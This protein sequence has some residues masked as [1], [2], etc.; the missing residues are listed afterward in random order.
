MS[1]KSRL[2]F[3]IFVF[4]FFIMHV[5]AQQK[6]TLE[7]LVPPA[8]NAAELGKY[9]TIPVGTLTGT[10][11]ISF[12]L[13]EI[14]TG[15]LK[16]PI[17]LSYHA[18]GNQVNQ[19]STDVG[20]GWCVMAGG[21][22]SRTVYGSPDNSTNGYFNVTPPSYSTLLG[23]TNYFTMQLYAT[24]P[25]YDLEPDLFVYNM[26]GRSGKFIYT[27]NQNFMTIPFDPI[28]IQKIPVSGSNI[29][30]QITDDNGTIYQFNQFSKTISDIYPSR[31]TISTWYLTSMISADMADTIRFEYETIHQDDPIEQHIY[32]IGMA[33]KADGTTYTSYFVRGD[34]NGLEQHVVNTNSYDELLVK[35]ITFKNGYIQ[36]NRNTVR[37]DISSQGNS[38]D[39]MLVYNNVNP[40]KKITF[41]HDYYTAVPFMDFWTCYRLKL[42]GFVESD[43][44][45]VIKKEHK[46]DY[47]TN[48]FPPYG[49]YNIDY[50]GFSNGATNN[51]LIPTTT[52]YGTDINIVSFCNGDSFCNNIGSNQSW[53][54]GNANREP[55]ATYMKTGILNKITYP[56]GGYTLFEFE[57]HQYLSTI[58]SPVTK[59]GGG[60]RIK[61]IKNYNIDNSLIKE[62]NYV[63][64]SGENGLGTKFFNEQNFYRN[65]EDVVTAYYVPYTAKGQCTIY[66]TFW[67]RNYLGISKYNTLN[68]L[69]SPILYSNVTK[70]EG[71]TANNIGKTIYNYTIT[72]DNSNLPS[73]F[74]NSGNYGSINNAWNPAVLTDE[75]TYKKDGASYTPVTK[76]SYEYTT[77]NQT[78]ENAFLLKQHK[79]FVKLCD[80][81]TDPQGPDPGNQRFGEGFFDIFV[82]LIN[83]GASRKTKETKIVY[84]QLNSSASTTTITNSQY[85]NPNN[86]YLTEEA[87]T[88]SDANKEITRIKYPQ[89]MTDA[90]S[91]VMVSKNILTPHLEER[92]YKSVSGVESLLS[93]VQT[94]YKQIG[95]LIER[96]NVK[97]STGT[98]TPELRLQFNQYDSRGNIREQQKTNG[99][100]E[101]Y[102]WGYSS[103][104]P[105]AKIIGSDYATVSGIVT[106]QNLLDKPTDDN[107]L[108]SYLNTLRT[109]LPSALVST[110]TYTPLIGMTSSTD[111]KGMT[112]YYNYDSFNRLSQVLDNKNYILKDY[113]YQLYNQTAP[114][115][116]YNT[117][118]ILDQYTTLSQIG[119]PTITIRDAGTSAVL[120][121][122]WKG[123]SF[124][125]TTLLP[126][127]SNGYYTVTIVPS[128][129]YPLEVTVNN[130]MKDVNSTQTW[131]QLSGYVSIIIGSN[132]Y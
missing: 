54:I 32:P 130:V 118:I 89:D 98:N 46:F 60:L 96:D 50:W 33:S 80:C 10:P 24:N 28:K 90:V 61:S 16:L 17:T 74:I 127:S 2:S 73:E 64:G 30:F 122:K 100:K 22:I 71:N 115:A 83:T 107:T 93:T 128:P 15:K 121:N 8:P 13:Y 29:Y 21:Q 76:T 43:P 123:W 14:N 112:T 25:A 129:S 102:L 44:G 39:E 79:Q 104:Y 34:Q 110:Y 85:Q 26:G 109:G 23:I 126:A 65:Y 95:N 69:G 7:S 56:T 49:S 45:M 51:S 57:P 40:I 70:Y 105:V 66:N 37:K 77:Y 35:K 82:Y 99:V 117:S 27:K 63:Y 53:T 52:V 101:V 62:D 103:I 97:A 11:E 36:F 18:S 81:F 91:T 111:P 5:H 132:F 75:T 131:T 58:N 20:L 31:N 114:P 4:L 92:V 120:L 12:P 88:T 94:T 67:Q 38:L 113:T 47:D 116:N 119:S 41:N 6:I 125:Y 1:Q 84:D 108:R 3:I 106:N 86:L 87:L 68:Y 55:S 72:A 48:S 19:K 9:G 124:P 42:T 78:T 59:I